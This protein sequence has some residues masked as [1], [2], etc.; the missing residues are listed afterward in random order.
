MVSAISIRYESNF[1][2]DVDGFGYNGFVRDHSSQG[3]H[4]SLNHLYN[5]NLTVMM[6]ATSNFWRSGSSSFFIFAISYTYWIGI[7]TNTKCP[8]R[9]VNFCIPAA[10][11]KNQVVSGGLTLNLKVRS[12]NAVSLTFR[13]TSGLTWPVT[14]L[15]YSQNFIM[16]IPRGPKAWPIFG[17]GLATPAKT[18]RLT[19]AECVHYYLYTPSHLN[20]L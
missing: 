20:Q 19:V 4:L 9:G 3:A 18:R 8:A 1:H 17:L 14:L 12:V 6:V 5:F 2:L 15:N 13:G 10:F 16:L 11:F 7:S